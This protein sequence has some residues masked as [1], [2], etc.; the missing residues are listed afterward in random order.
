MPDPNEPKS[1]AEIR[2]I[3]YSSFDELKA[4][5]AKDEVRIGTARDLARQWLTSRA[6][7]AP[8]GPSKVCMILLCIPYIVI[9]ALLIAPYLIGRPWMLIFVPLT[10][11]AMFAFHPTGLVIMPFMRMLV[12]AAWVGLWFGVSQAIPWLTVGSLVVLI[13]RYSLGAA[14]GYAQKVLTREALR[15]EN[16]FV[17][18][19]Q[20]HAVM[21]QFPASGEIVSAPYRRENGASTGG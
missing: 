1:V 3:S 17:F 8:P 21:L 16:I 4:A 12:W 15:N 11:V 20:R 13:P 19:Y 14:Y 9:L 7:F 10:V 2:E 6:R 18:A 5:I